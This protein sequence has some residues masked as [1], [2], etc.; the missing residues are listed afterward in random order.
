MMLHI[1]E[2]S[3]TYVGEKGFRSPQNVNL[4]VKS[5]KYCISKTGRCC[6][7]I[8]IRHSEILHSFNSPTKN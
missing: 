2:N 7:I 1:A 6:S 5:P 8:K 3:T 4:I